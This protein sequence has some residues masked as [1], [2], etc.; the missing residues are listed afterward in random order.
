MLYEVITSLVSPLIYLAN[1]PKQ[2][3]GG[4]RTQFRSRESLM[5]END[6]LQQQLFLVRG[7]FV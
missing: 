5:D 6:Q 4:V 7:E 1:L 3:V 2:L